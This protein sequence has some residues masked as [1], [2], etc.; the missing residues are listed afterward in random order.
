L[1]IVMQTIPEVP[2]QAIPEKQ[3]NFA[4]DLIAVVCGLLVVA[5]LCMATYGLDVSVGFF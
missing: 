1:E 4:L 2:A 5:F 3:T